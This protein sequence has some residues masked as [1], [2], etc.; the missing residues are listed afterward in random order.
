M[1]ANDGTS[2]GNKTDKANWGKGTAAPTAFHD[3]DSGHDSSLIELRIPLIGLPAI[4]MP[5]TR[6]KPDGPK[7]TSCRHPRGKIGAG[8]GAFQVILG[9]TRLLAEP[10][11]TIAGVRNGA[12][13][14]AGIEVENA[15]PGSA[16]DTRHQPAAS[17]LGS[18]LVFEA[19]GTRMAAAAAVP[20]RVPAGWWIEGSDNIA[21][22]RNAFLH[23]RRRVLPWAGASISNGR[24]SAIGSAMA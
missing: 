2:A 4:A 17:G 10:T 3:I 9:G 8:T 21:A 15:A 19:A 6:G 18:D 14:K 23:T 20:N 11:G 1:V 24:C 12:F 22:L 5:P 13:A 7:T 16:S